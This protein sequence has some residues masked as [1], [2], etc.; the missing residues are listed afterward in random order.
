[1]NLPQNIHF[2][3]LGLGVVLM[4]KNWRVDK[5]RFRVRI[6][7]QSSEVCSKHLCDWIA[8]TQWQFY[9]VKERQF[10]EFP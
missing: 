3:L 8:L 9:S 5:F 7:S 4:Q 2:C 10:H 6:L 1:M